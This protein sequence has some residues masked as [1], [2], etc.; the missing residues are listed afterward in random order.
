MKGK[1]GRD[2]IIWAGWPPGDY[3]VSFDELRQSLLVL[4][5]RDPR[6]H[7]SWDTPWRQELVSNFE[8]LTQQLWQAGIREV[9]AAGSFAEDKDH[10]NDIDGYS[11]CGLI[12]LTTG[13]LVRHLNLLDPFKI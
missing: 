10:P 5:P 3:E 2:S 13:E 9:F 4:G 6:E 8:T 7:T 12:Q 1:H 11:V